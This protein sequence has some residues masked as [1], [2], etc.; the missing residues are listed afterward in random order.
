MTR[1]S[2]DIYKLPSGEL[3]TVLPYNQPPK[4]AVLWFGYNYK[5]QYWVYKGKRDR[6]TLGQIMKNKNI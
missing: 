1:I 3:I 5:G 4:Q 2:T 6:R